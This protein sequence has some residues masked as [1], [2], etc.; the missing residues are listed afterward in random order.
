MKCDNCRKE[1]ARKGTKAAGYYC[2][3]KCEKEFLAGWRKM[4]G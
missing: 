2:S 1:G 3:K 4:L